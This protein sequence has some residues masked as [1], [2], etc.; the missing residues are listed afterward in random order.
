MFKSLKVPPAPI[1]QGY[2]FLKN[3]KPF[4]TAEKV[5]IQRKET[6]SGVTLWSLL[7]SS[8][9][10]MWMF[11]KHHVKLELNSHHRYIHLNSSDFAWRSIQVF[12][13][14]QEQEQKRVY[15]VHYIHNFKQK[16]YY[17]LIKD[18]INIVSIKQCYS[19]TLAVWH[20][21]WTK[22][23]K[24]YILICWFLFFNTKSVPVKHH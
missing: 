16:H 22:I 2:H 3:H 14:L 1:T 6:S 10:K 7:F 13:S 4:K 9:L 24:F 15:Y 17:D 21:K 11:Q 23:I 12:G 20:C 19:I 5:N 18:Q 8:L